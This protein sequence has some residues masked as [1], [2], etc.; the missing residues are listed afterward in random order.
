MVRFRRIGHVAS[1]AGLRGIEL[2]YFHAFVYKNL[3]TSFIRAIPRT[4][5]QISKFLCVVLTFDSC[6]RF[7]YRYSSSTQYVSGTTPRCPYHI[8]GGTTLPDTA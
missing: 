8:S 5:T 1:E 3:D 7:L 2:L 6:L 4:W